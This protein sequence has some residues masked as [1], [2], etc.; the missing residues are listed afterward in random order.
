MRRRG[1]KDAAHDEHEAKRDGEDPRGLAVPLREEERADQQESD[2]A[3][4]PRDGG[5]HGV[6]FPCEGAVNILL[7][8]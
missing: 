6:C 8:D 5:D 2:D 3:E 4:S 1:G 7:E